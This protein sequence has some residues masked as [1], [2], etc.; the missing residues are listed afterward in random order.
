MLGIEPLSD[1]SFP[2]NLI[3]IV[4]WD[5][6]IAIEVAMS[7]MF[8]PN[9][10][11]QRKNVTSWKWSATVIQPGWVAKLRPW[12]ETTR[13]LK[14][15]LWPATN[16]SSTRTIYMLFRQELPNAEVLNKKLSCR[17]R[18]REREMPPENSISSCE[19]R[20]HCLHNIS[21][22]SRD[23]ANQASRA[24]IKSSCWFWS[25]IICDVFT[26]PPERGNKFHNSGTL[27]VTMNHCA[28]DGKNWRVKI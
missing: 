28:L 13:S 22:G 14:H 5:S 6:M 2:T 10:T 19:N 21:W 25:W 26:Y 3:T 15:F 9:P 18:K 8:Q 11:I 12:A 16:H 20:F 24:K 27:N 17:E 4:Q 23:S 1:W 7:Y